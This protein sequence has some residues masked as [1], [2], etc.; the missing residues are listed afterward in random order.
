[1]PRVVDLIAQ[2]FSDLGTA[3]VPV[4]WPQDLTDALG[5]RLDSDA[6]AFVTVTDSDEPIAVAVG[7][8]DRR[9]PSPRRPTGQI[10]YFEWLATDPGHRREGAARMASLALLEWFDHRGVRAVDVHASAQARGL[11][12]SLGFMGTTALPMRR[13]LRAGS[14]PAPS[15]TP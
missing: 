10:G 15:A 14:D 9:L 13:L 2:M 11:Y 8:L 6:A 3:A 12:E 7:I 5:L 1:V 4:S